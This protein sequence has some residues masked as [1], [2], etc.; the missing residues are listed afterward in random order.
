[1]DAALLLGDG[2]ALHAVHARLVAQRAVCLG[3][4]RGE[5]ASLSPPSVPSDRERMSTFQ[6][7]RSQK[8]VYNANRSAANSAASSPP[9]RHESLRSHRGH[10]TDRRELS[11]SA[12]RRWS[13]SKLG[14]QAL[15][16]GAR[17]LREL[18]VFVG[19]NLARLRQLALRRSL[20]WWVRWM[21]SSWAF[22]RPSCFELR[23]IPRGG[24]VS[25]L[26]GDLLRPAA[27]AW[28]SRVSTDQLA[29]VA[30]FWR[31]RSTRPAVSS[32][33]CLPVKNGWQLAQTS[34]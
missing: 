18:G 10:R 21:A 13:R 32:S 12:E 33:F 16:I 19:E 29:L 3:T 11:S 5:P 28:R 2:D 15:Q 1:V 25:Q 7:R 14:L 20:R 27:S 9:C 34:T 6:P 23:R 26:P 17:Q 4:A 8:R 24:G 22:S 31:N 30:Y